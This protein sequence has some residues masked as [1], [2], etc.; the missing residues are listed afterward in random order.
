[1]LHPRRSPAFT[2]LELL[3]VLGI[4]A[5]LLAL[6]VPAIASSRRRA[7]IT[8]CATNLHQIGH[9]FFAY[10]NDNNNFPLANPMPPPFD[11]RPTPPYPSGSLFEPLAPYLASESKCYH[12]PGDI[13]QVFV[14]CAAI[15]PNHYGIS[16]FY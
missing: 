6:L 5:V 9:A 13:D 10:R 11:S 8:V 16:Y 4:I 12:C 1:M 3:V 14:P 15:S 7:K 2:L